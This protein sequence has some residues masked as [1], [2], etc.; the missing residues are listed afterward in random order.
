MLRHVQLNHLFVAAIFHCW[1][2][3]LSLSY[4]FTSTTVY[5]LMVA[6]HLE[7][8]EKSRKFKVVWGSM[9]QDWRV[10]TMFYAFGSNGVK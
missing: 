1:Y 6:T 9:C 5:F 8:R 2:G 7:N 10:A 3:N 4:L